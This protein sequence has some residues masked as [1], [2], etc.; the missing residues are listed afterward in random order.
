MLGLRSHIIQ[1]ED[2][3]AV[4]AWYEKVLNKKPYF[5]AECYI[6]FDAGGC[7]LGIFQRE[8]GYTEI[9]NNIE[10]YWG[11][12]D[13]SSELTRPIEL[14]ATKKDDV[15]DVGGGV[16]MASVIDPFGNFFGIIYNPNNT[17]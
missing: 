6:G 5:Q 11:V 1:A 17:I 16:F 13:I 7:E 14:G 12:E 2:I 9:G 4:A 10:I 15:V 8:S 3:V